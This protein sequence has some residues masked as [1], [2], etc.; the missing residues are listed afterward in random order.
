M[1]RKRPP[2]RENDRGGPR[3]RGEC[4][5]RQNCR[6]RGNACRDTI[7]RPVRMPVTANAASGRPG[8]FAGKRR[9]AGVA[10]DCSLR[11]EREDVAQRKEV[12]RTGASAAAGLACKRKKRLRTTQRF[13]ESGP[14]DAGWGEN[15]PASGAGREGGAPGAGA[16]GGERRGPG[17]DAPGAISCRKSC[18]RRRRGRAGCS[19]AR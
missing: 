11:R 19:P 13:Q 8:R 9:G 12:V 1:A 17:H 6:Y 18:R 7:A 10:E 4:T 5:L 2:G 14:A 3:T 15:A 16:G